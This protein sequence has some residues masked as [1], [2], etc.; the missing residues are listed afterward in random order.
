MS[1]EPT[2][3]EWYGGTIYS[4]GTTDYTGQRFGNCEVANA[5]WHARDTEIKALRE[6]LKGIKTF[7]EKF[8]HLDYLLSDPNWVENSATGRFINEVWAEIKRVTL[9][10]THAS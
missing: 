8:K 5:G 3:D 1:N 7:Y 10:D 2:F 6:K 4:R 9:G